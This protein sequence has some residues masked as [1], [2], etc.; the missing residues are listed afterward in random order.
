MDVIINDIFHL[1][2][3]GT[4][5]RNVGG[6]IAIDDVVTWLGPC[7]TVTPP[8]QVQCGDSDDFVSSWKVCDFVQG[9][10]DRTD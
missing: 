2:F 7:S 9:N 3:V 1:L 4:V 6:D 5:G 8:S 10:H